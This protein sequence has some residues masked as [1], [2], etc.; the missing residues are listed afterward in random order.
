VVHS[1][2]CFFVEVLMSRKLSRKFSQNA[3]LAGVLWATAALESRLVEEESSM[4][5]LLMKGLLDSLTPPPEQR[6]YSLA[7]LG[8][9]PQALEGMGVDLAPLT[10][11][12]AVAAAVNAGPEFALQAMDLIIEF[13]VRSGSKVVMTQSLHP[14][15][16]SLSE[17]L[18]S[19]GIALVH[20][21]ADDV[22]DDMCKDVGVRALICKIMP[23]EHVDYI[24][25]EFVVKVPAPAPIPAPAP[26]PLLPEVESAPAP[27]AD[28]TPSNWDDFLKA[29]SESGHLSLTSRQLA[30]LIDGVD[31]HSS[32]AKATPSLLKERVK[33]AFIEIDDIVDEY[34]GLLTDHHG[35]L[36]VTSNDVDGQKRWKV[37]ST[38]PT[39]DT[40]SHKWDRGWTKFLNAWGREGCDRRFTAHELMSMISDESDITPLAT[41]LRSTIP[42]AVKMQTCCK[43]HGSEMLSY[44]LQQVCDKNLRNDYKL[45]MH[46]GASG[47]IYW[48]VKPNN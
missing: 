18:A 26:Q 16:S 47:V 6:I 46:V 20:P 37:V 23:S 42:I 32:V 40:P 43:N 15:M 25:G 48:Q 24:K 34:M 39:P 4:D 12:N 27:V 10:F 9:P 5:D 7:S 11:R 28:P 38:A 44:H 41:A 17:K 1:I 31:R 22:S 35:A 21:D 45:H 36:R 19:K 30:V 29:W 2:R 13:A 14:S 3:A 33:A 8:W